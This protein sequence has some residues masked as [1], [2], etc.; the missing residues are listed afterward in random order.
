[1]L[2]LFLM[3]NNKDNKYYILVDR[4]LSENKEY[5]KKLNIRARVFS[6]E[7]VVTIYFVLL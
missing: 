2:T 5:V 7:Y 4:I 3:P 6:D 1:M